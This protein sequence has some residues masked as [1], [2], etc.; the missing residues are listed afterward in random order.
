VAGYASRGRIA[1]GLMPIGASIMAGMSGLL[2]MPE[3]TPWSFAAGLAALGAGAGLFIVPIAAVLQHRP[4]A[5]RKGAVQGA[6]CWLSWV[7]I[8]L[9]SVFQGTLSAAH[10][11]PSHVFWI[12][13]AITAAVGLYVAHSRPGA[14]RQLWRA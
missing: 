4:P 1:Y 3:I 12:T 10:V 7:G 13:G 5:D 14:I 2:G 11:S 9:A 6:A 8:C